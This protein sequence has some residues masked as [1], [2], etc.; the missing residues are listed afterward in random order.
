MLNVGTPRA[1][2]VEEFGTPVSSREV[3]GCRSEV[4]SFVQGYSKGAKA[5]RVVLHGAADVLTL[6]LWE[7]IGTPT[8]ATFDGEKMYYE[9]TYDENDK[10]ASVVAIKE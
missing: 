10:V 2:V 1:L 9:V 6:G 7:V 3:E 4:F 5:S 8:E